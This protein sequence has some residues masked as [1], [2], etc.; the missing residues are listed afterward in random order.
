[1]VFYSVPQYSTYTTK[2]RG[3]L[4]HA[5]IPY[6]DYQ[7][8]TIHIHY[9]E[10]WSSWSN[11]VQSIFQYRTYPTNHLIRTPI[12]YQETWSSSPYLNTLRTLQLVLAPM[13][14]KHYQ[15]TWSSSPYSNTVHTLP[16]HVVFY[17]V[18]QYSTCTTKRS[19]R[20]VHTAI[21]F[22]NHQETWSSSPCSNTVHTLPRDVVV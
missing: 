4:V 17:S 12:H 15:E 20:L 6:I 13:S 10:T 21:P 1:M 5:P 3:R 16:R 18:P 7:Y 2:R 19:D 22:I 14:Y 11:L 8:R 9:Q